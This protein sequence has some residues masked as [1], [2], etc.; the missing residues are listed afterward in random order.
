[1]CIPPYQCLYCKV[2]DSIASHIIL[3]H[4]M[5]LCSVVLPCTALLSSS[6]C[7]DMLCCM[8][9]VA[10]CDIE[11]HCVTVYHI[12]WCRIASHCNCCIIL[13]GTA[14]HIIVSH[15]I[16]QYHTVLHYSSLHRVSS[17]CF[18]YHTMTWHCRA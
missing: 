17:C 4:D 14:S 10:H 2:L 11:L 1:V 12:A 8:N 5:V 9:S 15:R 3:L 18:A 13:H 6:P 7:H 16:L